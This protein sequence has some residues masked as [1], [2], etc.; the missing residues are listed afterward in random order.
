MGLLTHALCR[1]QVWGSI[2][3]RLLIKFKFSPMFR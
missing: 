3:A 2:L 1:A